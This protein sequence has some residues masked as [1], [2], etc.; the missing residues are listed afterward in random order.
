MRDV[1]II[2]VGMTKFGELWNQ[3]LRDM[4]AEAALKAMENAGVDK[5]DSMYVGAMSSGLYVYQE[6]IASVMAEKGMKGK[7]IGVSF[8]G[9]GYG[10]DGTLWGGEILTTDIVSFKRAGHFKYIPLPGGEMSI[11]EPWRITVSYM[12]QIA[13]ADAK[14]Y[15]KS[16]GFIDKYGEK[17][18]EDIL[19]IIDIRTY[20]PLS[21][22]AGRLF[23]AVAA[24]IGICDKNTFEG[25]AAIALESLTLP[26]IREDYPLDIKFRDIMEIDFSQ[27]VFYIMKDLLKGESTGIISSKFH[28]TVISAIVRVVQKLSSM[29]MI[30]DV[31]LCGGVFQNMY[32][33]E[34]ALVQ[35]QSIG[36]NVHIHDKVPSN[37]AGISLGQAYII[38]EMLKREPHIDDGKNSS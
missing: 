19:K 6:H 2:G 12:K 23:D 24:L 35:L 38:R 17:K 18:I 3:S 31:V 21:S 32:I 26:D 28:N 7:V 34:R 30:Q 8:D 1:A 25:E 27:T 14:T 13:G 20:S 29:N 10:P 11:K 33:L 37:D 36:M 15:L 9:S 5:L 22:G 4:F 16:I